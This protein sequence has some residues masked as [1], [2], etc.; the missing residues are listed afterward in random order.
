MAYT[1]AACRDCAPSAPAE[2]AAALARGA[3]RRAGGRAAARRP[4][5]APPRPGRAASGPAGDR[6][7]R[8]RGGHHLRV[9]RQPQGRGAVPGRDPGVGRGHPR[10]ARRAGRLGAGPA[11]ALHRRADGAGPDRGR[12][13][14]GL[15]GP[16]RPARP[17]GRR[18][19]ADRP[20]LPV[21]LVPTQLARARRDPRRVGRAGRHSTRC[22]SAA[23][24]AE[25][26]LLAEAR[27]S[28]IHVV[29]DLRDERDL[30]RLCLRRAA[31]GRRGAWWWPTTARS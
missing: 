23:G 15:A 19:R 27:A 29:L 2:L 18:G 9:D 16:L 22:W 1:A 8:G 25:A 28:G 26:G 14:P 20:P 3:G 24:R 21:S 12:G 5:R 31:A 13:H 4:G 11:G 6:A 17:A 30:R 7:G 10:P